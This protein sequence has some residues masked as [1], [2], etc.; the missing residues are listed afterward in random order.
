MIID[1]DD[2]ML[3]RR[4]YLRTVQQHRRENQKFCYM[5]ET[6]V[7]EGHTV[8]KFWVDT[9]ISI[10]RQDFLSSPSTRLKIPTGKGK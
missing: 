7:N 9:S 10:K 4:N 3:W 5:N 2:V 8:S 6:W 1:R